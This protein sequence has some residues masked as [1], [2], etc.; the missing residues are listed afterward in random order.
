MVSEF[1]WLARTHT[2][3]GIMTQKMS[4]V[5][6]KANLFQMICEDSPYPYGDKFFVTYLKGFL[7]GEVAWILIF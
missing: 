6:C 2:Y 7:S 4:C 1:K 3:N 5:L